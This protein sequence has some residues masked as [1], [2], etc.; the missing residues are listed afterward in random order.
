NAEYLAESVI[1]PNMWW[2]GELGTNLYLPPR[3]YNFDSVCWNP[4]FIDTEIHSWSGIVD[5]QFK[6]K[7]AIQDIFVI[8]FNE[9]AAYLVNSGQMAKP[10]VG[11]N[12]LTPAEVNQVAD[13]LIDH[14]KAGQFKA[15]WPDYGAAVNL[16]TTREVWISDGWQPV[17][18]DV[19]RGGAACWYAEPDEGYRNWYSGDM[20]GSGT[21]ILDTAFQFID[22]VTLSGWHARFIVRNGYFVPNYPA[23]EVID[24]FEKEYHSWHYGGQSTYRTTNEAIRE[25][26]PDRPEFWDLPDRVAGGLFIPEKYK[27]STQ[28]GTPN[29][30]GVPKDG[31]DFDRHVRKIA[32]WQT[33]PTNADAYVAAWDRL[34]AA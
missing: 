13:F 32:T 14:K 16:H 7:A 3:I 5:R 9:W 8:A 26:W 11:I 33:W 25:I 24:T 18:Y 6:G 12:D 34:K 1:Y 20:P 19:R 23:K 21:E 17:E 28:A 27:W 22:F 2:P 30:Q 29:P 15:F 31:G 10:E 4:E